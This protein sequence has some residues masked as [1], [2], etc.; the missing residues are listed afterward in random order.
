MK[1]VKKVVAISDD[2]QFFL[3]VAGKNFKSEK[4]L[5]SD[6]AD[7]DWADEL[8]YRRSE[9]DEIDPDD[10]S[11]LRHEWATDQEKEAYD[12]G[13]P[14]MHFEKAKILSPKTWF[15]HFTD[16]EPEKIIESGF[17]G[18]EL[19]VL[20]LTTRYIPGSY[21][22]PYAL[23]FLADNI[24]HHGWDKYGKNAVLFHLKADFID[25]RQPAETDG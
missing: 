6:K 4:F 16:A 21:P 2:M 3:D 15:I 22:G 19:W 23:A 12:S 13:D 20:G 17:R 10:E 11:T 25:R 24:P 8:A 7:E 18:R 9:G 1:K 14:S 5:L